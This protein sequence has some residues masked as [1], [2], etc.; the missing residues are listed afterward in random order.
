MSTM[1]NDLYDHFM[2]EKSNPLFTEISN[3]VRDKIWHES[4]DFDISQKWLKTEDKI[5][6]QLYYLLRYT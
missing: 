3:I 6:I 2:K 1:P 4:I 5:F